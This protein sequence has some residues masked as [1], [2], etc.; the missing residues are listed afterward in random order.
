[1]NHFPR[2]KV[3][4]LIVILL[5]GLLTSV[6]H[7]AALNV[8][9][10]DNDFQ[11]ST[12]GTPCTTVTGS[13]MMGGER[14]IL[15]NRT[16]GSGTIQADVDST[17]ANSLAFSIGAATRGTALIQFDGVDGSCTNSFGLSES[18][19]PYDGLTL[20]I[21]QV[22]LNGAVTMRIYTDSSNYS[23]YSY[24]IPYS[25]A[26]PGTE[27]Y[28]PFDQFTSVGS[29][30]D[31][32][33]VA[34]IEILLDGTLIDSLDMTL[35]FVSSDYSRDYGDLPAAY[36]NTEEVD[37]GARHRLGGIYFGT[38]VD[39]EPDG[40]ES[41]DATGDVART[42]DETGITR[43]GDWSTG[44]GSVVIDVTK[45]NSV[46]LVCGVG[47]IDWDGDNVFE[48]SSS[49]GGV[50]EVVYNNFILSDGTVNFTSPTPAQYGG[51][52][53]TSLN[54][55]F[56]IFRTNDPLFSAL[57]LTLDGFGCPTISTPANVLQLV[58][59]EATDGE[60]E[61]YQWGFAPS[62]IT[63]GSAE[64]RTPDGWPL[65]AVVLLSTGLTTC[66]IIWKQKK[67]TYSDVEQR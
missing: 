63:L 66:F 19:N 54:A 36:S 53:P 28:F 3:Y 25:I 9:S 22:D 60:V 1:M 8:D 29:G 51:A 30:A 55:R 37:D 50:S 65:V 43:A 40:Q 56:R 6:V 46:F 10:F 23:E 12:F 32:G 33:S 48:V 20:Y 5:L 59:G 15:V 38:G 34:A 35:D 52:Y 45:P 16:S 7:A 27:I 41:A 26:S 64:T 2:K 62:A 61:D 24:A 67:D 14:D 21:Q 49:I 11:I 4:L 13:D 58:Y 42:D 47:F 18:L 44:T 39:S 31:F 57:G 17:V